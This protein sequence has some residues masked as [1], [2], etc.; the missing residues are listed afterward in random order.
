MSKRTILAAA[1]IAALVPFAAQSA[2][3]QGFYLGG[4]VG[5]ASIDEDFL[6]DDD[7]SFGAY[8]GYKF[9]PYFSLEAAYTNFGSLDGRVTSG[10]DTV[11]FGT[12]PQSLALKAVGSFPIGEQFSLFGNIGLHSW[13]LDQG[14][15]ENLED[16]IGED[17]ATDPTYGIGGQFD[18]AS[19]WS[20]RGQLQRYEFD[21]AD[22]DEVSLGV[23][24][25]F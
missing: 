15:G 9:N 17:S 5:N 12:D 24:Y 10:T 20:I 19:N 22:L 18:F 2:P 6:D 25:T 1:L 21:D 3:E 11:I 7:T 14:S 23:H 16:V 8:G 4:Q 13:D